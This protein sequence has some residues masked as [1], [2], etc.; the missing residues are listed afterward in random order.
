VNNAQEKRV[1]V[2]IVGGGP[3]G[4]GAAVGLAKHGIGPILLIERWDKLGGIPAKYPAKN[5]SVPTF[6]SYTRGRVL[7]GQQFVDGLLRQLV[8]TDVEVVLGTSVLEID[9]Q[10]RRLTV[11]NPQEGKHVVKADAIVFA[12]GAR[13]QTAPERGGIAGS[14]RS[15]HLQTMQL[16]ELLNRGKKLS[17][18]NAV[19]AG[20]DLV[21]Y[22]AAAKLKVAGTEAISM[23]DAAAGP[24]TPL[25]ARLYFRRWVRPEWHPSSSLSIRP[26]SGARSRLELDDESQIP[27]DALIIC[28]QLVPNAELLVEAGIATKPPSHVPLIGSRGQLSSPGCFAVGNLLGGFHGGQWCYHNGLRMAKIVRSYLQQS[29]SN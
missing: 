10:E 3:A 1:R 22:A 17:W 18:E 7:F 28:G 4:I 16:L 8:R 23:V 27:T 15:P 29:G 5:G 9:S 11:V 19:I 26:T 14:R 24:Q 13:E 20:S 21:A 6:V 25:P 2:A 12:T